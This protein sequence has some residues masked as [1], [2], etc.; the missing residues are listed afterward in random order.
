MCKG[1]LG[2]SG[3]GLV[4][5]ASLL[6]VAHPVAV[7]A[8]PVTVT[9]SIAL[10]AL[11]GPFANLRGP[12]FS[13]DLGPNPF[14]NAFDLVPDFF[15]WCGRSADRLIT[16]CFAGESIQMGGTTNGEAFIGT[17]TV[18]SDGRTFTDASVFLDGEFIA[19]AAITP[20]EQTVVQVTSPF[21]F[22]GTLRARVGDEEIFQQALVG[23]G[24]A[25]ARMFLL[26]PGAGFF[27]EN[28]FIGYAFTAPAAATPE[29]ATLLLIGSGAAALFTRRSRKDKPDV[30]REGGLA[31]SASS[32]LRAC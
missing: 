32:S 30:A 18:V 29:P 9:G 17:G 22:S 7:R 28:N 10:N 12:T 2:R 19:P 6:L 24:T 20:P 27:D 31:E 11:E 8:D 16:Q 26:E 15:T 13:V 3:A 1:V 21:T 4:C 23:S 5:L 25:T 14:N